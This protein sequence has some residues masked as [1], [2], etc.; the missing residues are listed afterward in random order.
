MDDETLALQL[1]EVYSRPTAAATWAQL[2]L[3]TVMW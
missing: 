1:V 3:G 2:G